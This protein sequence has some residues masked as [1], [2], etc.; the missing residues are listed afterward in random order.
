MVSNI[1]KL[2]LGSLLFTSIFACR[3]VDENANI[4]SIDTCKFYRYD[5]GENISNL[6]C[7]N[8]HLASIDEK[9]DGR[10]FISFNGLAAI[11]SLKLFD[12]AFTKK[13]KGWYSK[14][15]TFKASRM[16]T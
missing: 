9:F 7:M 11:D 10:G 8:C 4:N 5:V 6:G 15:G 16:D 14:T 3:N 2:S 12:Y 1:I 13:H